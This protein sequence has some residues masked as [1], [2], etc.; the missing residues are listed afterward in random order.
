MTV[1]ERKKELREIVLVKSSWRVLICDQDH[2]EAGQQHLAF[3]TKKTY[4]VLHL[5]A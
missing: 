2:Q 3:I 5:V 4:S 1:K